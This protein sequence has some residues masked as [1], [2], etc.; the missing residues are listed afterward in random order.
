M[1]QFDITLKHHSLAS[2][3]YM[4]IQNLE[5]NLLKNIRASI[6]VYYHTL[7]NSRKFFLRFECKLKSF[8]P[9]SQKTRVIIIFNVLFQDTVNLHGKRI[10]SALR[11]LQSVWE[12]LSLHVF[13]VCC[14]STCTLSKQVSLVYLCI[15]LHE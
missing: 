15:I 5:K 6:S 7:N 9:K 10:K 1:E 2:S 12:Y 14:F 13:Y 3:N 8:C 11:H 4:Y